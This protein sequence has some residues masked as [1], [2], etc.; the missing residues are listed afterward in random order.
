M[1]MNVQRMSIS[2]TGKLTL[3]FVGLVGFFSHIQHRLHY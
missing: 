2:A 1:N 3:F